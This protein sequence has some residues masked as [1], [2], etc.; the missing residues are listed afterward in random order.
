MSPHPGVHAPVYSLTLSQ[1]WSVWLTEHHKRDGVQHPRL[2]HRTLWLPPV[3]LDHLLWG[4]PAAMLLGCSSSPA[5]RALWR[6]NEVF[7]TASTNN[8]LTEPPWKWVLQPQSSLQM[9]ATPTDILTATSWERQS[10]LSA[11]LF[12]NFWL[13]ET[14]KDNVCCC[15]KLLSFEV[16]CYTAVDNQDKVWYQSWGAHGNINLTRQKLGGLRRS[17][18]GSKWDQIGRRGMLLRI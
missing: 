5:K 3:L 12:P 10:Q 8:H 1:S 7:T 18:Q 2:S 15:F 9:M 16:L 6:G 13:T 4:K 11:K 17:V 14:V